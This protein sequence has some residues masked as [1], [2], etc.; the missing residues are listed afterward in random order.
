MLRAAAEA[1]RAAPR[2]P[3][4][5]AAVD[6]LLDALALRLT[7]GYAPAA[8]LLVRA[9]GL[10][11]GLDVADDE[12]DRCGGSRPTGTAPAPPSSSGTPTRGGPWPARQAQL[13]RDAGASS[14]CS[15]R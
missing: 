11:P 10:G 7:E 5:R 14:T 12:V 13:A 6:V 15:S 1:A 4:R 9:V 8:P 2:G 3:T